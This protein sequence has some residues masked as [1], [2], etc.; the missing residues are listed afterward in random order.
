MKQA[1]NRINRPDLMAKQIAK[2]YNQAGEAEKQDGQAW[3]PEAKQ[4]C[5]VIANKFGIHVNKVIGV[6]AALS[7]ATNWKQNIADAH[8]LVMAFST[9]QNPRDVVV[10]TYGNNKRKAIAILEAPGILG[11][12]IAGFLNSGTLNKTTSFFWNIVNPGDDSYVTIDRHAIRIAIGSKQADDIAITEKRYKDVVKSYQIAAKS[13]GISAISLQA[14]VWV[15][16]RRISQISAANI[17]NGIYDSIVNQ[18]K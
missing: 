3:Y 10:T 17:E 2:L 4:I 9:G 7:P 13:L 18:I 15:A 12:T 8:N 1:A 11:Q 16:Y 14:A 6:V 5:E